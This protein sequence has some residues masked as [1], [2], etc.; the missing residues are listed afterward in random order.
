M[1]QMLAVLHRDTHAA[2]RKLIKSCAAQDDLDNEAAFDLVVRLAQLRAFGVHRE[3]HDNA[4]GWIDH[5]GRLDVI[6]GA[7][8]HGLAAYERGLSDC[9][10]GART[11]VVPFHFCLAH[12]VEWIT[13]NVFSSGERPSRE[14]AVAMSQLQSL[15]GVF[16][17]WLRDRLVD[18]LELRKEFVEI[19][20]SLAPGI[21]TAGDRK[22]FE[23][24]AC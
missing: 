9:R 22:L 1:E 21:M 24:C 5:F 13:D 23:M 12:L 8:M 20:A 7:L 19:G 3:L 14:L 17:C 16:R 10:G 2:L 11:D 18:D 6:H 4:D 15:S